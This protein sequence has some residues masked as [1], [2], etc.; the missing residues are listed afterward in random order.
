MKDASF[1][2]IHFPPNAHHEGSLYAAIA[3]NYSLGVLLGTS[4]HSTYTAARE[5]LDRMCSQ[6]NVR[7]CW[8]D[9]EYNCT[10]G[11]TLTPI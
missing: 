3:W 7:L 10:D 2:V 5:E 11:E 4:D 9:G 8:F 6:Y 1:R